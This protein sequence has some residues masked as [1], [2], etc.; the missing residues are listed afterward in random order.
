[1]KRFIAASVL[2]VCPLLLLACTHTPTTE[3]ASFRQQLER[4]RSGE[5]SE[6]IV[7][8]EAITD[9]ELV[10]L[11]G[12]E[13]LQ[14]LAVDNLQATAEG[15]KHLAS[16]ENLEHVV[17]GGPSVNDAALEQLS[18][19]SNLR[20]LNLPNAMFTDDG[21]RYLSALSQLTLLRFH[22]TNVSNVGM[23]HVAK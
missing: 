15:L 6:I 5:T 9:N 23:Q 11:A 4:V 13:T 17:L 12:M 20:V 21:L 19:C 22:S 1:M 14:K 18:K 16:A 3:V 8:G 7:V 10:L 2:S